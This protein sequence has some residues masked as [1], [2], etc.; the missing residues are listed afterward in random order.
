MTQPNQDSDSRPDQGAAASKS[1]GKL[2]KQGKRE[3]HI[4]DLVERIKES[5]DKMVEDGSSRGDLKLL[6]RTLRELRYGFKVFS[7]YRRF[8]KVTVFGSARTPE[9]APSYSQAVELGEKMAVNDW[10]VVTG[11]ASGIMEAGHRGAG[12]ESSMGL[13]IMLPF[14]QDANPVIAGDHKLVHMKYFFTRKVM[15]VKE[16]DAVVCLPGGFGTLDE[17]LEV[18]TLLQTGK[19]DM[20]PVVLLDEPGG[21]YWKTFHQFIADHLLGDGMISRQDLSIYMITDDCNTAVDEVLNFYRVYHSMR[22]VRNKLVFRL[23]EEP[24]ERLLTDINNEFGDIVNR[25]GFVLSGPLQDENDE[26]D[27][28]KLPRLVFQFDRRNLGRLR[29]LIDCLNERSIEPAAAGRRERF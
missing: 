28:N 9:D 11:A 7:P 22:Y 2:Q 29:Q 23:T 19:R 5:A 8:R 15:F 18:L 16:C 24:S 12:R 21:D 10:L 25:G 3:K 26:Q 14:E 6:S 27:L 13:N 4:G 20:V 17:A 1:P